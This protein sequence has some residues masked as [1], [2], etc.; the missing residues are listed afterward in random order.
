MNEKK[1]GLHYHLIMNNFLLAETKPVHFFIRNQNHISNR[2]KDSSMV[3]IKADCLAFYINKLHTDVFR[4]SVFRYNRLCPIP[5]ITLNSY[6]NNKGNCNSPA[7]LMYSVLAL[8][9]SLVKFW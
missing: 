4:T 9:S 7:S 2:K 6:H 3:K 1:Y 8:F 5:E